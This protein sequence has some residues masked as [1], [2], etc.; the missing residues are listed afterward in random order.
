MPI[1]QRSVKTKFNPNPSPHCIAPKH[2]SNNRCLVYIV[3]LLFQFPEVFTHFLIFL[4]ACGLAG[5]GRS[6]EV[7]T[8]QAMHILWVREHNRLARAL[9]GINNHWD[10]EKLYQEARRIL[11]AEWQHIIYKVCT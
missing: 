9:K 4:D 3:L 2:S 10:D 5:D 7:V 11:I 8:L 6:Q 1:D